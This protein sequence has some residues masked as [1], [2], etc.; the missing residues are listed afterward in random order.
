MKI[1]EPTMPPMTI[2]VAS[3]TPSSCRG[4]TGSKN[5]PKKVVV[6]FKAGS[7]HGPD[8]DHLTITFESFMTE[9]ESKRKHPR[10]VGFWS[11]FHRTVEAH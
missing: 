6:Q 5:Q 1:P 3:N 4:L 11:R 10:M 9:V 7:V 2:M 8:L